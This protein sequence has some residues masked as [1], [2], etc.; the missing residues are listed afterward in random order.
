MIALKA[1]RAL[2]PVDF[3]NIRRDPLL[4]WIIFTPLLQMLVIRWLIPWITGLLQEQ[5]GFDLRPF[6]PLLMSFMAMVVPFILGVVIGFLLLDQRD[7]NTLTALQVTPLSLGGY[8]AYRVSAP[9]VAAFL[10]TILVVWGAGLVQLSLPELLVVSLST[11]LMAP[12]MALIF[13]SF[14]ENK[15]QGLALSKGSG[16]FMVPA[17]IAY[18]VP[19]GWQYLFGIMPTYWPAKLFWTLAGGEP[20]AWIF[21][22]VSLFSQG[23]VLA[24]TLRHFYRVMYR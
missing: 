20:G 16:V 15:V 3:K 14:A 13:A 19:G 7:D 12:I 24:L 8:L 5:V 23:V 11:A 6:Y 4:K 2:G 22:L 9:T 10:S 17:L 18:F 21:L 1:V